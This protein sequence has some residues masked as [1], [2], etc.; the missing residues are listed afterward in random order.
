MLAFVGCDL[1]TMGTKAGVVSL[2]G[3]IL[4]QSFEEVPVYTPRPGEVEQSLDEIEG[5]AH[6]TIRAAL[7]AADSDVK[8]GGVA[9]SGQMSGVGSIDSR[10]A[11]AT[12]FD[13]WLDSRCAP[14]IQY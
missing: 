1:G 2:D 10:F 14:Y 11:P 6:R 4:G 8:I 3:R 9:F 7:A 13:S 12:H 5:S